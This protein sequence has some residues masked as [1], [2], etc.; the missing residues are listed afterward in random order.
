[1]GRPECINPNSRHWAMDVPLASHGKT[2]PG[3]PNWGGTLRHPSHLTRIDNIEFMARIREYHPRSPIATAPC[4]IKTLQPLGYLLCVLSPTL[5]IGWTFV[6][7]RKGLPP[8]LLG[9]LTLCIFCGA[10]LFMGVGI[11]RC[12]RWA[13][14]I[15]SI[16]MAAFGMWM[17]A[18]L[19]MAA[20]FPQSL[21]GII[22]YGIP[23]CAP[24]LI[25]LSLWRAFAAPTSSPT[26]PPP[27]P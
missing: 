21:I 14:L 20:P 10:I 25:T 1:M 7:A 17:S 19:L 26:T 15:G 12:K 13:S 8:S 16:I 5:L 3:I 6:L 24:L 23:L 9:M 4:M 2:F 22:I 27:L 11:A 18:S